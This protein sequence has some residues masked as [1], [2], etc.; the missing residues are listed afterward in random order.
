M[1]CLFCEHFYFNSGEMG[2]SEYTPAIDMEIRCGKMHW[3]VK[4]D[5]TTEEEFRQNMLSARTCNDYNPKRK[6][7]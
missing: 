1:N 6:V 5:Q 3:E 4:F 2:Y 7:T